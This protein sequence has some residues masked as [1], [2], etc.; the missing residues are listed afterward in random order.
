[1]KIKAATVQFNHV[2]GDKTANL[3]TIRHYCSQAAEAKVQILVFPEMCI[4]GYWH[5][6]N[7]SKK[8]IESLS[9][10][11]P[12]GPSTQALL[13]LASEFDLII[14][15]GLIECGQDGN[16]YNS[17]VVVEPNGAIHVHRKLHCFISEHMASGNA[18]TVFKTQLGVTLGVLICWD[19][20][21]VENV[22]ITAL[23]GADIL[24]APHQTGG[25][26]SRS[27]QGMKGIDPKFW[28]ERNDDPERLAHEFQGN[29]GRGW[30]MRWLP[31]RAH[32]NGLF[33]LFSNGV[34]LDDNEVRTGN[35]MIIDC[36][37]QIIAESDAIDNDMVFADLNMSLLDK[38]TGR[39]WLRGRRPELYKDIVEQSG[40]ELSPREARFSEES[41]N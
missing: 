15:A 11:I 25:C 22:R 21:L 6:R 13:Q 16:F 30:L 1:M 32:D 14:G 33:L 38:C 26:Q 37:G 17:Y 24:I 4:T 7:L 5:V 34:G 19:N 40:D 12:A 9:E 29:K 27:P 20:N 28:L 2:A 31:A 35:A 36:Y 8:S 3:K 23:K 18:Y 10:S 39:R 41:T